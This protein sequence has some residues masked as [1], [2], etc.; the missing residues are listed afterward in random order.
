[1]KLEQF[2]KK[3]SLTQMQLPDWKPALLLMDNDRND[4]RRFDDNYEFYTNAD[5]RYGF[6]SIALV[7]V[8]EY[9]ITNF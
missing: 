4:A 3:H 1:M 2:I 8:S 5:R 9:V 6:R 7:T